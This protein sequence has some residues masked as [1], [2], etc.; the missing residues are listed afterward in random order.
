MNRRSAALLLAGAGAGW[1]SGLASSDAAKSIAHAAA[2]DLPVDDPAFAFRTW[3]RLNSD[4]SGR[5]LYMFQGGMV[6]GFR[7]QS[8]DVTLA[9]FGRRLYGY[10]SCTVR[11][12]STKP[13]GSVAIR[14]RSWFFYTDA[15]SD[16]YIQTLVN[17]YTNKVVECPP[18]MTPI[19]EQVHTVSGPRIDNAPFPFESSES[20]RPMHLDYSVM[21]QHVWIR[22]NG[23]TR[24]KP[25][26]TT[27]WKLEGDMLTHTA[28][29]SDVLDSA[30]THIPNTTSHNLVAEWQ[31]WMNM[32][33][34]P[35]HI[36]FVG[37]GAF[38]HAPHGLPE[39]FR[40]AVGERFPGS[41]EEPVKWT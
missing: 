12:A 33:G 18:R 2:A 27:W 37:N 19:T 39:H 29:L 16:R 17:P 5:L 4:L 40:T 20:G 8:D 23:F 38:T 15:E 41:L 9:Q 36:L 24:F 10:R 26:D 7:P 32:H 28:A 35:G 6:Y 1:A 34:D 21:G 22:R 13:D 30:L 25:T 11:K 3:A 31:T 14:S